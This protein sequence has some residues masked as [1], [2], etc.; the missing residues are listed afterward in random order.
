MKKQAVVA[1]VRS[2]K[3]GAEMLEERKEKI[4]QYC[5][6]KKFDL[7]K[8]FEDNG[9]IGSNFERDGWAAMEN[10][11]MNNHKKISFLIVYDLSRISRNAHLGLSKIQ[12]LNNRFG[13]DIKVV[14][15][16]KISMF[17]RINSNG[18]KRRK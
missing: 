16:N 11:L 7:V 18:P 1:Y 17:K 12:Y 5:D 3:A 15:D 14:R 8:I 2:A 6:E 9:A 4:V 10:F 13:I